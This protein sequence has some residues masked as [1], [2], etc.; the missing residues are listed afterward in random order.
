M[1]SQNG[2]HLQASDRL[3]PGL[4]GKELRACLEQGD[5]PVPLD[6]PGDTPAL[7]Q[8]GEE[9]RSYGGGWKR[10]CR[11]GSPGTGPQRGNRSVSGPA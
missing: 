9:A 1:R 10:T 8:F 11:R 5:R 2:V 6:R 7:L 4:M 3:D